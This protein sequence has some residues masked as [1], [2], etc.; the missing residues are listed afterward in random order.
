MGFLKKIFGP[1]LNDAWRQLGSEIGAEFIAG[2]FFKGTPR[3][4]AR[5]GN[6][7]VT[8]DTYTV[9]TGKS[10]V[11]FTRMRAPFIN[12]DGFR[13]TIYRKSMFSRMG[14]LL[15]MQDVEVGGPKFEHLGPLFGLPGYLDTRI[16]ESGYPQFDND[17]IIKG[18]DDSKLKVLFKNLKI[19]E[20]IEA[21]PGIVLQVKGTG[22]WLDRKK[23]K[24]IDELYFQVVGVIKDLDRLKQLFELFSET[25][26]SL[27]SMGTAHEA[28]PSPR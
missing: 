13:F 7:T 1:S 21:Q 28:E 18:S 27:H 26:S 6:W 12:R 10:S 2:S 5:V 3:V 22:G 14:K 17:F 25:L 19:R 11:T 20:L 8:L 23:H 9:S 4:E 15:G 24:G 16:V